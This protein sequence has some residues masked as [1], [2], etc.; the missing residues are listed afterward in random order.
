M[1]LV[2][3]DDHRL[4]VDA[5]ATALRGHGHEVVALATTPEEG[6]RA[7][8]AHDPDVCVLDLS[9]PGGSGLDAAR[10]IAAEQPRCKVLI[11]SGRSDPD[12]IMAALSL[13][14]A[15]FVLKEQGLDGILLAL[16][17]VAAGEV[18]VDAHLLR[19]AAKA[20]QRPVRAYRLRF[21]TP[22]EREALLRIA[23]GESTKEIAR[24]M[25]VSQ[26]TART[27]VQNVLTKLGVRSRLQAAAL[28]A[29]EGLAD[30]LHIDQEPGT[31]TRLG[32]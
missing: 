15:G 13:G 27:H 22:R 1:R 9:F 24:A 28:V 5:F 20:P 21:L 3:C 14:A 7:V 17:R 16:D 23:Q 2:L 8:R 32:N 26:S 31:A 29:K 6:Y 25:R 4:L 12:L 10:R 11:L 19:A 18:A 30:H